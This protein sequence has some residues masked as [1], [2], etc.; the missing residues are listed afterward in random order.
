MA[1]KT[2][3]ARSETR[4]KIPQMSVT[5]LLR[6]TLSSRPKRRILRLST[7]TFYPNTL[8]NGKGWDLEGYP[9]PN[10]TARALAPSD[11]F[12]GEPKTPCP[13]NRGDCVRVYPV[14]TATRTEG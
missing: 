8:A 9:S 3:S 5:L 4:V 14:G 2:K 7:R 12:A 10:R 13:R 1:I 6:T 11:P